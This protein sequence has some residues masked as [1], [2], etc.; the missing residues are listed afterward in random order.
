MK[1]V[2]GCFG[3]LTIILMVLMTVSWALLPALVS[4]NPDLAAI[5]GGFMYPI[6]LGASSCCCLSGVAAV[7]F[8]A[9]GLSKKDE[10][11]E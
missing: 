9:V 1:Y 3:C 4:E 6:Q 10:G 2:G 11:G 8:L 5:I 7:I